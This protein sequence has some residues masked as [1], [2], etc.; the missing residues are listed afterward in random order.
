MAL[1]E[2]PEV[3]LKTPVVELAVAP[4]LRLPTTCT[5]SLPP[6]AVAEFNNVVPVV[7]KPANVGELVVFIESF[8]KC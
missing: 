3:N 7:V 6:T 5:G 8:E 2:P 1:T 4:K